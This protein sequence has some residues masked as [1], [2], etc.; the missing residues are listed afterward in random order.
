MDL[1]LRDYCPTVFERYEHWW[2]LVLQDETSWHFG[3][4]INLLRLRILTTSPIFIQFKSDIDA[5][6]SI[7]RHMTV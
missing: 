5:Q 7:L 3:P 2:D 1:K 6:R 4:H